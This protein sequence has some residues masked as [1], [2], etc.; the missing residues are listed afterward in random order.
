MANRE[1]E[2]IEIVKRIEAPRRDNEELEE[3]EENIY[4]D[5]YVY[6]H[7]PVPTNEEYI[8][9]EEKK[10]SKKVLPLLFGI[11]TIGIMG[12]LGFNSLNKE[13]KTSTQP[14]TIATLKSEPQQ[15]PEVTTYIEE[16]AIKKDSE[17]IE[18][19]VIATLSAQKQQAQLQQAQAQEEKEQ[20]EVSIPIPMPTTERKEEEKEQ[21]E[22]SVPVSTSITEIKE[23]EK[24]QNDVSIPVPMPITQLKEEEK[25]PQKIEE[26]ESTVPKKEIALEK[27]SSKK[28]KIVQK[29]KKY[30]LHYERIKPRLFTVKKGD[31]LVSIAKRFYGNPMDFKRIVR[32][33]RRLRSHKTSL[34]LGEKLIIP[35]KDNKTTR[36]YIIVEKGNTLASISK[37]IYG[38][39]DKISKIVRA[40]YSIK[41]K[42]S[43][44]R[45][46]Q[47]V[48]VPR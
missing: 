24:E 25:K 33:N 26:K 7:E 23:E 19:S 9:E 3:K 5:E 32:A 46:G 8:Q 27:K 44:L 31:S 22:V 17:K 30:Q 21:K 37:N 15:A 29:K 6:V 36:R 48:Y 16:L 39:T 18:E 41:S 12:Y 11:T 2:P 38:S 20:K 47:K 4:V 1:D 40:N 45:L 14:T 13:N 34:H 35:R 28:E 10:S 43:T 42:K